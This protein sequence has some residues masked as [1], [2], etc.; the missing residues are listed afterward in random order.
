MNVY[1]HV[2]M[3]DLH[4]DVES[5]PDLPSNG[6]AVPGKTEPDAIGESVTPAVPAD[7][8]PE[9]VGLISAWKDLPRNVRSAMAA[10]VDV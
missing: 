5:L 3:G 4:D 7:A 9:L 2:A 6:G 8:P 10:L 1:T